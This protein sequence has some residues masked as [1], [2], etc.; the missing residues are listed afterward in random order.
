MKKTYQ[1]HGGWKEMV[2]IFFQRT[3]ARISSL[4]MTMCALLAG[5]PTDDDIVSEVNQKNDAE[6]EGL[7]DGVEEEPEISTLSTIDVKSAVNALNIFFSTQNVDQKVLD[8]LL[9]VDKKVDELYLKSKLV[10]SKIT[11]FF[12]A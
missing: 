12:H 11:N 7:E 6:D 8:S 9:N 10:Q 3:S 5:T 4:L 1:Y 2:L